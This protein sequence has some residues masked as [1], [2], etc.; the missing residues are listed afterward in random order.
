MDMEELEPRKIR[1]FEIGCDLSSHSI[2]E[3][4]EL[5]AAL[6]DEIARIE[7]VLGAK[8]SSRSAA[9]SVFKI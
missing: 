8:E 4:K 9:D 5:A 2:E 7:E 3:L 1:Q 6:R